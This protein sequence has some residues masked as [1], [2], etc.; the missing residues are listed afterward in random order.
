MDYIPAPLPA[1]LSIYSELTV[2]SRN[3]LIDTHQQ[4]PVISDFT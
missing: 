3:L 4:P 1:P 2:T